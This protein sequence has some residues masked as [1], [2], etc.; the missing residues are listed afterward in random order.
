MNN[1]QYKEYMKECALERKLMWMVV[2]GVAIVFG[3]AYVCI[4]L[5]ACGVWIH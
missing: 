1:S 4:I 2:I 3:L 5:Q